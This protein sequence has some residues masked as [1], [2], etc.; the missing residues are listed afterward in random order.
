MLVTACIISSMF[1]PVMTLTN[2]MKIEAE[3]LAAVTYKRW[4]NIGGHYTNFP[5]SH[6]KGKCGEIAVEWW[7]IIE[8]VHENSAFRDHSRE[9]EADLTIGGWNVDVKTWSEQHWSNLG[10][11]VS[12]SQLERLKAKA[13]CIVWC[14]HKEV[15]S[16]PVV[17]IR[18]WS[19]I[20]DISSAVRANTGGAGMRKIDNYQLA[21]HDLRPM[22]DLLRRVRA[23]R[24]VQ[25]RRLGRLRR[26][27]CLSRLPH[28]HELARP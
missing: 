7:S 17:T 5:A 22:S 28:H 21:E 24:A 4:R 26:L 8:S 9:S 1:Q 19:L 3:A 11:C 18:G 2:E 13:R 14:T 10:R 25:V 16:G 23:P 27:P 15:S 20:S 12:V 6:F